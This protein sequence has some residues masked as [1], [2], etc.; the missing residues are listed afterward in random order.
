MLRKTAPQKGGFSVVGR[1]CDYPPI[2]QSTGLFSRSSLRSIAEGAPSNHQRMLVES[3]K[4][5]R[6]IALLPFATD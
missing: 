3:I 1:T 5:A 6:N 2:G 4:R